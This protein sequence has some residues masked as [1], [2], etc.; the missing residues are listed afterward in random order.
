MSDNK[1]RISFSRSMLEEAKKT[2]KSIVAAKFQIGTAV[3]EIGGLYTDAQ[4]NALLQAFLAIEK[5]FTPAT[6]V[7]DTLSKPLTLAELAARGVRL[8]DCYTH[9]IGLSRALV[10]VTGGDLDGDD[11]LRA[12]AVFGPLEKT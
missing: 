6:G 3:I 8:L 12:Y 9:P 5:D 1:F 2:G 10:A 7:V 4:A 11:N